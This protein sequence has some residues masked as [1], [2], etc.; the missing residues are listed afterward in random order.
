MKLAIQIGLGA[1]LPIGIFRYEW[2][3]VILLLVAA[4]ALGSLYLLVSAHVIK[5]IAKSL[6]ERLAKHC[7]PVLFQNEREQPLNRGPSASNVLA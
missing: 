5:H 1:M 2:W 3:Q 6:P 7:L 4:T